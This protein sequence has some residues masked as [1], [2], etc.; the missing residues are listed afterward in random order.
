MAHTWPSETE[1]GKQDL[2]LAMERYSKDLA[3]A[4]FQIE[5]MLGE[6]D[7]VAVRLSARARQVGDFM[8][9]TGSGRS[10]TIGEVHMFS[11]AM[12]KLSSTGTNSTSSG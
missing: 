4:S 7:R 6:G 12:R 3:D 5:N 8:G 2:K 10:Y 1:N 11:C 9:M